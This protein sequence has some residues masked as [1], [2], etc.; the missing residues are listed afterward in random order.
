M[1]SKDVSGRFQ[2]GGALALLSSR[3]TLSCETY[4]VPNGLLKERSGW[5]SSALLASGHGGNVEKLG[6]CTKWF[7]LIHVT[8]VRYNHEVTIGAALREKAFIN[9][10]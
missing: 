9:P 3:F 5:E 7:L 4:E 8:R 6:G 10:Y 1:S 2:D